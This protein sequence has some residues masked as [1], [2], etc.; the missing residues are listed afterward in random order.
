[1]GSGR[2]IHFS[3]GTVGVDKTGAPIP[4][5]SAK[6]L[7]GLGYRFAL[8][9]IGVPNVASS[10][11]GQLTASE[12]AGLFGAGLAVSLFQLNFLQRTID[13]AQGTADA[14][15][16]V[17]QAQAFGF[18]QNTGFTLWFDLEG[19]MAGASAGPLLD[20][21]NAWAAAVTAGGFAAGIYTGKQSVL[22]GTAISNLPND[23]AYWQAAQ[24]LPYSMPARGYQ[25]YQLYPAGLT[26]ASIPVDV[27]VVQQDF[28][29][30]TT[31]FLGSASTSA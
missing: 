23:C 15:Y 10:Q 6:Q 22:S 20:Y 3:P 11:A 29:G 2:I 30:G 19:S 21:V 8:R 13:A 27:D 7:Y 16:L 9:G 28:L 1:M 24:F 14:N 5:G 17:E 26:I 25:M 18:P 4:S 12:L 31:P